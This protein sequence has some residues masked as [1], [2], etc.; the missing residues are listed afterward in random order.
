MN[1]QLRLYN[2]QGGVNKIKKSKLTQF[3][4]W[5]TYAALSFSIKLFVVFQNKNPILGWNI[6]MLRGGV[7]L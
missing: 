2:F 6:S 5:A 3:E 1:I 4:K 7:Y